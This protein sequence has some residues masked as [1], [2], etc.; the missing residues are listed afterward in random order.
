MSKVEPITDE[1]RKQVMAEQEALYGHVPKVFRALAVTRYESAL[2]AA[3]AERDRLA[4]ENKTLKSDVVAFCAPWAVEYARLHGYPK[5]HLH[6][7]HFDILEKCGGR[8][9]DFTRAALPSTEGK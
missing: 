2:S 4:D 7:T 8:M 6:P 1:E 9:V 3:L 5:D